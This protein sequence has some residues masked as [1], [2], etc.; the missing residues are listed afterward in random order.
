MFGDIST[1][2][3]RVVEAKIGWMKNKSK[4][5]LRW[6]DKTQVSN[7]LASDRLEIRERKDLSMSILHF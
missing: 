5:A 7:V 3:K 6:N 4:K 2:Y 1:S